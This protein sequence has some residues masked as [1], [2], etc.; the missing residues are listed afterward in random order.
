MRRMR[1]VAALVIL[2]ALLTGTVSAQTTL[3]GRVLDEATGKPLKGVTVGVVRMEKAER[4]APS[5]KVKPERVLRT[6]GEGRFNLRVPRN[7]T[8]LDRVVVFTCGSDCA[9]GIYD[10]V[11]FDGELPTLQD[12]RK[13]GVVALDLTRDTPEI[14]LAVKAIATGVQTIMVPMRDGV[15]LATDVVLPE[16][17]GQFPAILIRTPYGKN[18]LRPMLRTIA[19]TGYAAVAQDFRGR[20][21]SEGKDIVF[22]TD[23]WGEL[24]D[25]YDTI[26][27]VASQPWC[28]GKVGTMGGSA[29][30]ITQILTAGSAPP[31]LVCQRISVACGS[32]YHHAAFWGGVFRKRLVE[33]WLTGNKFH[34]D[35]LAIILAHPNYDSYW[36]QVDASTRS[37]VIN[38]P[39]LFQSGW[40]DCFSQG[41]IDAFMWRQYDGGEGARGKQKLIMGPWTHG[42]WRRGKWGDLKLPANALKPPT[43][44]ADAFAWFDYYLKGLDNGVADAPTVTYYVMGDVDDPNAPGNE[45]RTSDVFPIPAEETPFYFHAGGVLDTLTG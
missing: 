6:D 1:I 3:S 9:N 27:W 32:L 17:E 39:G 43:I 16:G 20:F 5:A 38:V 13:E 26:E 36:K 10:G 37:K 8:G 30:G 31:H 34:P 24:Q 11:P 15:R 44:L 42:G 25:G 41:T 2:L 23:A 18:K 4:V 40:Y 35:N 12:L 22:M 29:L 45:W 7:L 14:T 28:N 21:E 19:R 33:N